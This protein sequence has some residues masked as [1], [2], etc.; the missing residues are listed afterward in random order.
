MMSED[1]DIVYFH[2]PQA[3]PIGWMQ[4]RLSKKTER[5]HVFKPAP[6]SPELEIMTSLCGRWSTRLYYQSSSEPM[7]QPAADGR[8]RCKRCEKKWAELNGGSR[9]I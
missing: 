5:A 8:P 2:P 6:G 3:D 7:L 1:L 4:F 9:S